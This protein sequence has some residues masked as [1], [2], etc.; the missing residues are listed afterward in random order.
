MDF[1]DDIDRLGRLVGHI[2]RTNIHEGKARSTGRK[3]QGVGRIFD[4]LIFVDLSLLDRQQ[5]P[6]DVAVQLLEVRIDG[7]FAELIF[8]AFIKAIGDGKAVLIGG[9]L[10]D[11]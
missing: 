5:H 10:S 9:K 6:Q 4:P 11:R 7:Q 8:R 3:G 2:A 1:K